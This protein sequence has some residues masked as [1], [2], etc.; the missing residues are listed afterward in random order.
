MRAHG[1][2]AHRRVALFSLRI[3][4]IVTP[5]RELYRT[6]R[7]LLLLA[8]PLFSFARFLF[9]CCE[10][11]VSR[12]D[13]KCAMQTAPRCY[14]FFFRSTFH[15]GIYCVCVREEMRAYIY[16]LPVGLKCDRACR[17]DVR[18]KIPVVCTRARALPLFCLDYTCL[19][20]ISVFF[21][22]L[23]L[24]LMEAWIYMLGNG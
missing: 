9:C 24:A 10:R 13:G 17:E 14:S 6:A 3:F 1:F 22:L 18:R 12:D 20:L 23:L 21:L 16:R 2:C 8:S 4:P 7:A 15:R 5:G 11:M 19:I